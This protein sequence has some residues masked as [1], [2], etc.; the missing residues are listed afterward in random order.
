M[1]GVAR[2]TGPSA[3]AWY[4]R[5][6]DGRELDLLLEHDGERWA[7]E[8]KLTASPGPD[9]VRRLN[10]AADMVAATRRVLVCRVPAVIESGDCLVCGVGAAAR[11]LTVG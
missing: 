3:A 7:V 11:R 10:R 5:T 9:D 4:F 8:V 6:S 2:L 1:G